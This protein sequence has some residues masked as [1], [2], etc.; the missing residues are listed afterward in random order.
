M[1]K[2]SIRFFEVPHPIN[3]LDDFER[4]VNIICNKHPTYTFL[5]VV[6]LRHRD[7]IQYVVQMRSYIGPAK[8]E[9]DMKSKSVKSEWTELP[10]I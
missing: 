10:T 4:K 2:E 8:S 5:G 7:R 3:N 9:F 1:I 6:P